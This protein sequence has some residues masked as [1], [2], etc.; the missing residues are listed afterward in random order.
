MNDTATTSFVLKAPLSGVL[1]SIAEVPDPVF[2]SKMVG[3]G[4]SIDPTSTVVVAPCAGRIVQLHAARHAVTLR[5]EDGLEILVHVGLDTVNLQGQGFTL[6]AAVGDVVGTGDPL[7]EFDADY[8]ATHARSLLTPVIVT[9]ME[10]VLAIVPVTRRRVT[11]GVD[12]V[13]TLTLSPPSVRDTRRGDDPVAAVGHALRRSGPLVV[14]SASGLHAR[15]AA[16]LASRA[17]QFNA[18]VH[19]QRGSDEAN[20]RSVVSIMSLEIGQGD[21]IEIVARGPD[22]DEAIAA[23]STLLRDG[24]GEGPTTDRSP[25]AVPHP[26]ALRAG[27]RAEPEND[28]QLLGGIPASP[29]VVVGN[30]HRVRRDSFHI[31][32]LANDPRVERR[33]L[34]DALERAKTEL[35]ELRMRL[36]AE[37]A[38]AKAAMFAAHG[39]LLDDPDLLLIAHAVIERGGS[40]AFGWQQAFTAHADRL[41]SLTNELLAARANDIRD[42]GRRV[43]QKLTGV[44]SVPPQYPTDTILVAEDLTPS[45]TATLDRAAV[46]GVC[47]TSGGASSHIAI[48]ARALD[49]P[50]VTGID[51]R[52]LDV[53]DGTP[54]VLDGTRGMLQLNPSTAD[55]ARIHR[56]RV[57]QAQ[58]RVEQYAHAREP[59][60]TLDGHRVEVAAN[61]GGLADAE[62]GLVLGAEAVGLLRSEF[63][64]LNRSTPP[65][66]IEQR[67][68]YSAVARTLGRERRVVIRTLDVGGD[69]PLPY[70]PLPPE[71]NPFLGE[72]GIRVCLSQPELL[73]TQVRAVLGAAPD[74][75]VA[76]MFPMVATVDEWRAARR[77]LEEERQRLGAPPIE[78]GI[79]VEVPSAAAMAEQFAREVDFFSIGT[80]DLTQYTLAMD[81]GHP[82]LAQSVDGLVPAVLLLIDMTIR[83]ARAHGRWTS[84][85]GGLASDPQAIPLLIGLGVEELSV[86]V[87]AIPAVKAQ[88]RRLRLDDCRR[89][90]RTALGCSTAT[91]VRALIPLEVTAE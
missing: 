30:I 29:G 64:F 43:L 17:K 77:I 65:T 31:V 76:V 66:E 35:E 50:L 40:A 16:V 4:V 74:G 18:D 22:A 28:P 44:E 70:L 11:A 82:R 78:V 21:A 88:I 80:N 61:I 91:A 32:E 27:A 83:A 26:V 12:D 41:A 67:E 87:P 7:I 81:R 72:R 25:R 49:V 79:M 56:I 89:L 8:L 23:L 55:I 71:E 9:S 13:A 60:V 85:C 47:S 84:V 73:R 2:S 75:R 14:T 20:A 58:H 37:G 51:P 36:G 57:V 45:D 1:V 5:T 54:A 52:A 3:D 59:A 90:A 63:L 6:L 68:L 42:V 19:V 48:L 46:R 33:S 39:E 69:K 10:R 15:P 34:D 62:Q 53:P 24:L 38:G 86:S